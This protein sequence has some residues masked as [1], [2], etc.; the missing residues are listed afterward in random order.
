MRTEKCEIYITSSSAKMLSQEIAS[1]MRGR[2]L[3]WELFPF[4]FKE[5]LIYKNISIDYMTTKTKLLLQKA[6]DEYWY[7]GGFPE[8]FGLNKRLRI[9]I[10]QEYFQ[11]ILFRDL[12]E[13][14]DIPHPKALYDLAHWLLQNIGALYSINQLFTYL[15]SM[16]HKISKSAV[17][18][19]LKWLEDAYFLF[20]VGIFDASI[21]KR[22]INPKK[23]YCID[24]ALIQSLS[25][26]M[27]V[28]S[29]HIL[30][31]IVFNILRRFAC[32]IYYYKTK[33]GKEIDFLVQLPN[34]S[35]KI[36]QVCYSIKE[37]KTIQREMTAL[38][39][40]MDEL[41]LNTAEIITQDIET[42]KAL[43]LD[44]RIQIIPI[45]QFVLLGLHTEQSL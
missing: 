10:H 45:W 9:K 13:R 43:H 5:F 35:K 6:F 41:N 8:V 11:S 7:T 27:L 23:I 17:S 42:N 18:N 36:I 1:V 29:G 24:H 44:P 28:N 2:A 30:E 16:N 26:Q 33:T 14:Y 32:D 15:Q 38:I 37:I 40:A 19:Y 4:S 12:I 39:E 34:R 25:T 22:N 21:N 3:S 31:N 20:S